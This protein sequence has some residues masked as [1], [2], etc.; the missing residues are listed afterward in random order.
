MLTTNKSIRILGVGGTW[1]RKH[2]KQTVQWYQKGSNLYWFLLQR[3]FS[4]L[5][6]ADGRG[7]EWTTNLIGYQWWR[8][9]VKIVTFGRK[10]WTPSL[11]DWE[12][13]GWNLFDHVCPSLVSP[14]YWIPPSETHLWL[15][16][17]GGNGGF[18]ACA[19]GLIANTFVTFCTPARCDMVET[20]KKARKRM[21]FWIHVYSD[22][23]DPI[24]IAGELGDAKIGWVRRFS[25]LTDESGQTLTQLGFG[26]DLEI[27]V[28]DGHSTVLN[29]PRGFERLLPILSITETR[30]GQSNLV[31][32]R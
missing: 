16:S 4:W 6:G 23:S 3:G 28:D 2:E 18:F 31:A 12:V 29:D 7:F 32:A 26:P 10:Q 30:H 9:I 5:I 17:H 27:F 11:N 8:S 25:E 24:Q 15:H 20:I 14:E 22:D 21:G 19:Q 1:A 13:C